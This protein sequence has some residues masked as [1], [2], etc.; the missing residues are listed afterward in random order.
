MTLNREQ[1][2]TVKDIDGDEMDIGLVAAGFTAAVRLESPDF[3]F[4]FNP[5]QAR[6]VANHILKLA[7]EIEPEKV[8]EVSQPAAQCEPDADPPTVTV[9]GMSDRAHL[10]VVK[11]LVA[12]GREDLAISYIMSLSS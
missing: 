2:K 5:S 8:E 10:E 7:E 4:C 3:I 11:A 9:T 1:R 6:E 12:A